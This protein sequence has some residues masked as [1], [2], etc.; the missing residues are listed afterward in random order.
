MNAM[1]PTRRPASTPFGKRGWFYEEWTGPEPWQ[2]VC[3]TAGDCPR[4][5]RAFLREE[6]RSLGARWF[7]REYMCS[8]EDVVGAV[9]TH[10]EILRTHDD[11]LAP[12]R[13]A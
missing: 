5:D 1:P 9:F 7:R 10:A 11:S 3:V 8:F 4:I 2:R 13:P 6:E 12:L